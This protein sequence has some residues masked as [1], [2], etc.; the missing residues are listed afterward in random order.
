LPVHNIAH[1]NAKKAFTQITY[2]LEKKDDKTKREYLSL[3]RGA[4]ALIHQCGLLQTLAFYLSKK[5][6]HHRLLT[7]QFLA[8]LGLPHNQ[9]QLINGYNL[10]LNSEDSELMRMT[11]QVRY[12]LL[13]LKRYAEAMIDPKQEEEEDGSARE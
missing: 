9:D 12:Y 10:L 8:H 5:K 3:V 4:D 7:S 1:E 13:W 2:L 11:A 6:E